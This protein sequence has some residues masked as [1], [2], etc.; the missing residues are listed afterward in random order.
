MNVLKYF[1]WN[2]KTSLHDSCQDPLNP[3]EM[4]SAK[5]Q[6]GG[7]TLRFLETFSMKTKWKIQEK[8]CHTQSPLKN[9]F[10]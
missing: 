5:N 2:L 9:S 10:L 4:F 3:C 8:W 7:D 1:L 6:G